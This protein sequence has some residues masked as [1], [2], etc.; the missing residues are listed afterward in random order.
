M[1][2]SIGTDSQAFVR[3]ARKARSAL[4]D[5]QEW[6]YPTRRDDLFATQ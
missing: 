6:A 1:K 3:D 4:R 2:K 5:L